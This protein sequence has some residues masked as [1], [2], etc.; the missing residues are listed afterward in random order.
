LEQLGVGLAA[1]IGTK[2]GTLASP[3]LPT[4]K[5]T[6]QQTFGRYRSDGTAAGTVVADGTQWR[7]S[8]QG[9]LY[10]GSFGAIAEYVLSSQEVRRNTTQATVD[11][12]SWEVSGTYV[13]TGER[14]TPRGVTP[15]NALDVAKGSWGAI[16][17]TARY[18]TLTLDDLVVP[19]FV[20]SANT[21]NQ[22]SAWDAGVNWYL[23]RAVKLTAEYE[24]T[25]FEDGGAAT[26]VRPIER[27]M[28]T[29]FQVAF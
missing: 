19:I 3:G 28:L 26:G 23:N 24:E 11:N 20:S 2:R 18:H 16:E 21:A 17:L 10:I 6:A 15:R 27:A 7:V 13:L 9:Q 25:R 22:A 14:A 8:P 1:S 12:R 4:F 29:R 5:T